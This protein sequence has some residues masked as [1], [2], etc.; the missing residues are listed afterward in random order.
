MRVLQAHGLQSVLYHDGRIGLSLLLLPFLISH[1]NSHQR[2]EI[3]IHTVLPARTYIQ[4]AF[5]LLFGFEVFELIVA[6]LGQLVVSLGRAD[7]ILVH[8]TRDLGRVVK[9]LVGS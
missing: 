1:A 7:T 4:S 2:D 9:C 8:S 5:G 6:E 3:D